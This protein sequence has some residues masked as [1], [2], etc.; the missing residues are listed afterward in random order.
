MRAIAVRRGESPP[1]LAGCILCHDVPGLFR[2]GHILRGE[3][4]PLLIDASWSEIHLIELQ[5]G[6]LAQ[7]EAGERL[8][9]MLAGPGLEITPAGHR[10]VWRA[11]QKGLLQIDVAALRRL[12]A[13]RG[14][15]VFTL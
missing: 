12:N 8:A 11:K 6:D 4:I 2:K 1:E 7:R 10:H 9:R 13:I 15:A 14:I 3:D 5:A